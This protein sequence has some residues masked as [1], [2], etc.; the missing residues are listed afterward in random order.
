MPDKSWEQVALELMGMCKKLDPLFYGRDK[1]AGMA[2]GW[3][4]ALANSGMSRHALYQ[5][6]TEYYRNDVDGERA[7]IGRLINAARTWQQRYDRTPQGKA[8]L[9]RRRREREDE[10]DRKLRDGTWQPKGL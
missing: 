10:L 9:E 1:Q 5:A 7:T 8:E 2:A 6:P 4:W 3:G